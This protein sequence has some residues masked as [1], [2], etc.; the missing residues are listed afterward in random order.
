MSYYVHNLQ[1][2]F[3]P[4]PP[5]YSSWIDYWERK[6]GIKAPKCHRTGCNESVS[7]GAHVQL[8]DG[9]NEWYIVPLCHK[10]NMK[11]GQSFLVDGALVPVNSSN[12]IL[13]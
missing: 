1:E 9:G 5:G 12:Q 7:E 11:R 4:S 6:T 13:W 3:R 10:C 8:V 2:G